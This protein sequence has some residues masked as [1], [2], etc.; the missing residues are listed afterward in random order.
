MNACIVRKKLAGDDWRERVSRG[1]NSK[2][3][4]PGACRSTAC[5]TNRMKPG[6]LQIEKG[7]VTKVMGGG[8]QALTGHCGPGSR[9]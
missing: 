2:G 3:K 1:R 7:R 4:G 5:L 8:R 6:K 9:T